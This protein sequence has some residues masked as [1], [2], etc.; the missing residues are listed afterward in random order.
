MRGFREI[1]LH[2]TRFSGWHAV[3]RARSR[4]SRA[5]LVGR[6]SNLSGAIR[7]A[8]SG[9]LFCH[10]QNSAGRCC[11]QVWLS[12]LALSE[13]NSC[14]VIV[15]ASSNVLAPAISCPGEQPAASRIYSSVSPSWR[16]RRL[17]ALEWPCPSLE[18]QIHQ[19]RHIGQDDEEN[20][21]NGLDQTRR[22]AV[23]P[24]QV[25]DDAEQNH[26]VGDNA[27]IRKCQNLSHMFGC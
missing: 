11:C 24:V 13:S 16:H 2:R 8:R 19:R 7:N 21:P 3:R 18:G 23:A 14:W 4:S 5:R 20:H 26:Q 22:P 17:R 12:A 15:P 10:S 27:K 1:A 9:S 6:I 25:D